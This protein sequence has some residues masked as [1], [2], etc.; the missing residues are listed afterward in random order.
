[1]YTTF[2]SRCLAACRGR[3]M[4]REAVVPS[5]CRAGMAARTRPLLASFAFTLTLA[6]VALPATSAQ[7]PAPEDPAALVAEAQS[8]WK[9]GEREQALAIIRKAIRLAP[10]NPAA[11]V[12]LAGMYLTLGDNSKAR[13]AVEDAIKV[14]PNHAPAHQRLGLVLRKAGD[15]E[16]AIRAARRAL[17]LNPDTQV[18]ANSHWTIALALKQ[19]KRSAEAAEEFARAADGYRKVIRAKPTDH[20]AHVLLGELLFELRKFEEA[21]SVYRRALELN[22]QDFSS[23]H[24][25]GAVYLN[26]GKK[27]EAVRYFQQYLRLNPKANDRIQI[28]QRIKRLQANPLPRVLSQL[29]LDAATVG[30]VAWV[31]SLLAKGADANFESGFHTPLSSAAQAGQTEVVKLLLAHGAKDEGGA[32]IVAAYVQGHAQIEELLERGATRPR[33]PK[34]VQRLLFAAINKSDLSRFRS[35]LD[36]GSS[37]KDELLSYLVSQEVAPIEMVRLLLGKGARVNQKSNYMTPLMHAADKGHVEVLKLLLAK[38]AQVNDRTYEGTALT[39]AAGRGNL[40]V[41]RLLLEAGADVSQ[42]GRSGTTALIVAAARSNLEVMRL[43]L[44]KGAGVNGTDAYGGATALMSAD[45]ADKVKLLVARGARVNAKDRRSG[46][47]LMA[48]AS[49]DNVEVVSALLSSGADVNAR[50]SEGSTA[51]NY[52]LESG[53][54]HRQ[55]KVNVK[56]IQLLLG[57][58]ADVNTQNQDGETALMQ[59]VRCGNAEVVQLLL[60]GGAD[61]GAVDTLDNTAHVLAYRLG[62]AELVKLLEGAAPQKPPARVRNAFL[63]AAVERQ[64]AGKVKELLE[65]GADPNYAFA[66]GYRQKN[67]RD[68]VLVLAAGRE[69]AAIVQMLLDKG[70]DV[71]AQGLVYGSESGI[72]LGTALDAAEF[73]KHPDVIALLRR[74]ASKKK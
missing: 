8:L 56:V 11:Y 21:E 23:A 51:L 45:S 39:L 49:R 60:K 48:A 67:I 73:H 68:T 20:D 38:G 40:D 72:K 33:N 4:L 43:L 35:L 22:P 19:L 54:L 29:L 70:A 13:S 7:Q 52:A 37:D 26:Q 64:D 66:V 16:G 44:D 12:E 50:N 34:V 27:D 71:N 2:L 18:A 57:K 58:G 31:R 41:V 55:R 36:A 61:V 65:A 25:L 5:P 9:K 59:A 69:H 10:D 17:S 3:R 6:W 63:R 14:A 15:P 74:A 62:H 47:A 30:D 1:M 46:T 42:Q 32:A 53:Y 24:N 28:E